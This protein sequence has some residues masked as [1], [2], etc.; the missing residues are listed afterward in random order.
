MIFGMLGLA[1]EFIN[2]NVIYAVAYFRLS[3]ADTLPVSATSPKAPCLN[4][5]SCRILAD[6]LEI[7]NG[8]ICSGFTPAQ[9]SG[10][11]TLVP[12]LQRCRH[13]KMSPLLIYWVH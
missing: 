10:P 12:F 9:P 7:N 1:K 5:S 8:R 2:V 3:T 13:L 6:R 4:V 11:E